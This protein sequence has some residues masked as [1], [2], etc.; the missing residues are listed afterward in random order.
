MKKTYKAPQIDIQCLTLEETLLADEV[1]GGSFQD[2]WN[3]V[4]SRF[5]DEF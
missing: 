5:T 3:D 4:D 2:A 1:D